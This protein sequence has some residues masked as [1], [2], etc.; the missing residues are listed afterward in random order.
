M[1]PLLAV[2]ILIV[3]ANAAVALWLSG[4]GGKASTEPGVAEAMAAEGARHAAHAAQKVAKAAEREAAKPSRLTVEDPEGLLA[5]EA[6]SCAVQLDAWLTNQQF[7]KRTLVKVT[8]TTGV[9]DTFWQLRFEV[10]GLE[11][12]VL[13]TFGDTGWTFGWASVVE[14]GEAAEREAREK[15]EREERVRAEAAAQ[16]E[17]EWYEAE[18]EAQEED[19]GGDGPYATRETHDSYETYEEEVVVEAYVPVTDVDWLSGYVTSGCA[20]GL[21]SALTSWADGVAGLRNADAAYLVASTVSGTDPCAFTVVVPTGMV[22]TNLDW[23][24][25]TVRC[26]YS[27]GSYSFSL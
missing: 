9:E 1:A 15:A 23:V 26:T 7:T 12:D 25:V 2:V 16:A 3:M 8:G 19:T 10:T 5:D 13:G 18:R 14:A 21:A 4:A 22:D 11:G 20:S 6:E 27:G 17:A 24:D